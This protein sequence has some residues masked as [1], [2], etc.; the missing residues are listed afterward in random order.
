MKEEI[1]ME[2]KKI[3]LLTIKEA[4]ELVSGLSTYQIRMMIK[5][6]QLPAIKA[7]S[8]FFINKDVLIKVLS[9]GS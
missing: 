1:T 6:G 8:K 2:E 9:A 4:S 5:D 3:M 7:G